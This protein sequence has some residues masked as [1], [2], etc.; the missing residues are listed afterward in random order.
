MY[1][2]IKLSDRSTIYRVFMK[3]AIDRKDEFMQKLL[4]KYR[5]GE[6]DASS[7]VWVKDRVK[8][9]LK[10]ERLITDSGIN[11]EGQRLI[12]EG[13]IQINEEGQYTMTF[14]KN[15]LTKERVFLYF[16][17]DDKFRDANPNRNKV[18]VHGTLFDKDQKMMTRVDGMI[19]SYSE[20][21]GPLILDRIELDDDKASCSVIVHDGGVPDIPYETNIGPEKIIA[22][23]IKGY[24]VSKNAVVIDDLT[25]LGDEEIKTLSMDVDGSKNSEFNN[26]QFMKMEITDLTVLGIP[27]CARD[28]YVAEKWMDELRERNWGRN[29]VSVEDAKADQEYWSTKLLGEVRPELILRDEELLENLDGKEAFWG[30]AAMMDLVPD[31]RYRNMF[32]IKPTSDIKKEM[33]ENI[34][35]EDV[36]SNLKHIVIVDPYI[37]PDSHEMLYEIIG[38]RDVPITYIINNMRNRNTK[39][40][41]LRKEDIIPEGVRVIWDPRD[42]NEAHS[43]WIILIE[44]DGTR[45]IWGPDNSMNSYKMVG[46]KITTKACIR[47]H[48]ISK[49]DDKYIE[50]K[51]GGIQ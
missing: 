5:D 16:D 11:K 15:G 6:F 32:Y 24:D 13:T 26:G 21:P 20:S 47:Y 30:V 2:E 4:V 8:V 46:D 45:Y 31:H 22:G 34:F 29:F 14:V 7:D 25:V 48:P 12:N 42:K 51:L 43:R 40:R 41:V 3:A 44:N 35:T 50:D 10:N 9:V 27:L 33:T 36:V 28:E 39:G 49:L 23:V 18:Q 38:R 17:R 19:D 37:A 1:A